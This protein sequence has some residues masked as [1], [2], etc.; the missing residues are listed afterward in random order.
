MQLEAPSLTSTCGPSLSYP[1]CDLFQMMELTARH[2]RENEEL[3]KMLSDEL[4][5][6]QRQQWYGD[7]R[8]RGWVA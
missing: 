7:E 5:V 3:V 6:F 8:K 2:V 1:P 4:A